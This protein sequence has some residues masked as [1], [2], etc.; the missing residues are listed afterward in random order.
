MRVD[1][2]NGDRTECLGQGDY[3]EVTTV[4]FIKK[5]EYNSDDGEPY[6]VLSSL[7]NA[8]EKP[9]GL[10]D[11]E[12]LTMHDCPKIVLDS[13]KVVYGCQVWWQEAKEQG[14]KESEERRSLKQEFEELRSELRSKE[15]GET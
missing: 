4:Y 5:V 3:N 7:Q 8:E 10:S 14:A 9:E 6:L 13:G 2:W 1:V 15:D 11:D 12:V